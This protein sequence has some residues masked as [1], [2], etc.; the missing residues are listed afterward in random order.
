MRRLQSNRKD[1]KGKKDGY[2]SDLERAV[3]I[4]NGRPEHN[5][6][7]IVYT[8]R[9]R[10]YN[11]DFIYE[12]DDKVLMVEVK[13]LLTEDDRSKYLSIKEN[14]DSIAK[15][16]SVGSVEL[17]FVFQRGDAKLN[18]KNKGSISYLEWARRSGFRACTGPYFP[19]E[20][21]ES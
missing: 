7:K 12:F 15:D 10:T 21:F 3:A 18:P 14:Y 5:K 1:K 19:D 16:L 8:P 2:D 4:A 20:W 6:I 11:P 17:V 9:P 13:G